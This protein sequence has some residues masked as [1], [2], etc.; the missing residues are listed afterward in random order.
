V[1]VCLSYVMW[2]CSAVPSPHVLWSHLFSLFRLW[3]WDLM[4]LVKL[5]YFTSCILEKY[6]LLSLPLVGI[7][8]YD[9]LLHFFP[10]SVSLYLY[11][12]FKLLVLLLYVLSSFL[13]TYHI[14]DVCLYCTIEGMKL[15]IFGCLKYFLL[16]FFL[17]S[18]ISYEIF[19]LLILFLVYQFV[20]FVFKPSVPTV[21]IWWM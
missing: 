16:L 13:V 21:M 1:A 5:P 8:P 15:H 17:F 10:S 14:D 20:I 3:C 12:L 2:L 19:C 11:H 6:Y 4:Q 18:V 7:F 9:C